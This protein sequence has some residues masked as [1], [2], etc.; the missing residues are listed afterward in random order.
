MSETHVDVTLMGRTYRLECEA[1]EAD[2]LAQ[3]AALLDE[4]ITALAKRSGLS[5][6]KLVLWTAL[7]VAL[8]LVKLQQQ[9]GFDITR[10]KRR[11]EL[12]GAR[13]DGVL[14]QY[15]RPL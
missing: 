8:D 13:L 14:N 2:S 5:G 3:A 6:E 7:E 12:I 1:G 11:I 15:D 10:F 9:G 4:R